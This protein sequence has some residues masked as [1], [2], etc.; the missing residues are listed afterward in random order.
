MSHETASSKL[1]AEAAEPEYTEFRIL[2]QKPQGQKLGADVD[3]SDGVSLLIANI[4]EGLLA[5]WNRNHS[6]TEVHVGDRIVRVNGAEGE[7]G[8]IMAALKASDLMMTIRRPA[9]RKLDPA[10][11][12][13]AQANKAWDAATSAANG[14]DESDITQL[15][16]MASPPRG[17]TEVCAACAYILYGENNGADVKVDWPACKSHL[18]NFKSDISAYKADKISIDVLKRVETYLELPFFNYDTLISRSATCAHLASWVI[19]V[20]QYHKFRH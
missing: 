20:V 11:E 1:A 17:C 13:A 5:D 4:K 7:T 19:S 6:D 16:S 15:I 9:V 8:R 3:S 14:L 2:M 18:R 10:M 12:R